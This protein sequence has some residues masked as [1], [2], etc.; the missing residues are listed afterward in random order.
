MQL[1]AGESVTEPGI[2]VLDVESGAVRGILDWRQGLM[3]SP[4]ARFLLFE[5]F[6]PEDGAWAPVLYDRTAGRA[7]TWNSRSLHLVAGPGTNSGAWVLF[8]LG[9]YGPYVAVD[10]N[11][12][13][14]RRFELPPLSALEARV[15]GPAQAWASPTDD[16]LLIYSDGA[17][18]VVGLSE[19]RPMRIAAP[20]PLRHSYVTSELPAYEVT[21]FSSGDGF[22]LIGRSRDETCR[23]MRYDWA[24]NVLSDVT[25]RCAFDIETEAPWEGPHLSPDGKLIAANTLAEEF[26]EC[27]GG[28]ERLTATSV[29]DATTGEE[30]FRI[31]GATWDIFG[32]AASGYVEPSTYWLPDSSGLVVDTVDGKRVVSADGDWTDLPKASHGALAPSPEAPPLFLLNPTT[33]GNHRREVLATVSIEIDSPVPEAPQGTFIG[34]MGRWGTTNRDVFFSAFPAGPTSGT[35]LRPILP[36]VIEHPP[37]EERLLLRVTKEGECME[38]REEPLTESPVSTCL[39]DEALVEAIEH[40]QELGEQ[41]EIWFAGPHTAN[42]ASVCEQESWCTWLYVRTEDG[43]EGWALSD[44]L[45]WATGEPAPEAGS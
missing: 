6:L 34:V 4:N 32:L 41:G 14:V 40:G 21:I 23:V 12:Q 37:F 15:A 11:L 44:H 24:G 9:R 38:V 30:L 8:R 29:F 7:F 1:A 20:D 36:P 33:V 16:H 35:S 31:R 42:S 5:Q 13:A 2:Y 45:R 19:G 22:G 27:L 25:I 26:C 43:T 3:S 10:S 18:H 39:P 28:F 17:F